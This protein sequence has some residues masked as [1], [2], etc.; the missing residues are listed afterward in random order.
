MI[1]SNESNNIHLVFE[2][3]GGVTAKYYMDAYRLVNEYI[4]VN[5]TKKTAYLIEK[6]TD[7][8]IQ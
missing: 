2:S 8:I 6:I 1:S 5:E 4:F 7:L 3:S